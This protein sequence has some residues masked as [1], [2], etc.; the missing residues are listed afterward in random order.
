LRGRVRPARS[1][2]RS[3]SEGM[4]GQLSGWRRESTGTGW[5]EQP[6]LLPSSNTLTSSFHA[7]PWSKIM[8]A[9][10]REQA[11][12]AR[13]VIGFGS[14]LFVSWLCQASGWP[15]DAWGCADVIDSPV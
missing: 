7:R 10:K 5:E 4:D 1:P 2:I 13:L 3:N 15:E 6:V 9:E 11:P 8:L 14:S 12:G